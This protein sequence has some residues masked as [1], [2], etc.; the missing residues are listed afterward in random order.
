MKIT[1][2]GAGAWG[3]AF[4]TLLIRNG[5]QVMLWSHEQDV[6]DDITRF[7]TNKKFFPDVVLDP[8]IQATHDLKMALKDAAWIVQ[9]IPVAYLRSVLMDV[10]AMVPDAAIKP[11]IL[12]SKGI[13]QDSLM[14][15]SQ[16]LEEIFSSKIS[17]AIVAGPNFAKELA[18]GA[19]TATTVAA[20]DKT[21]TKKV[22]VL[23]GNSFFKPFPSTDPIGAQVGGAI[24]NVIAIAV[25]ICKGKDF[26][27]NTVAYVLTQG[28]AEIALLCEKLGGHKETGYGFSGFGDLVLTCTSN[29]SK[30][31][32]VGVMLGNGKSLEEI[33]GLVP[34]LP[35]GINTIQSVHELGRK[36]GLHLP[37]C[38]AVYE[39]IFGN[40]EFEV[41]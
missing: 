34:V 20:T 4:A 38:N 29:L 18:Q 13:E 27:D 11:W 2:L 22:C 5:H 3:T 39:F 36:L 33:E 28:L 17:Y 15:S 31:F 26:A 41:F 21:L 24:K 37:V 9:A 23:L 12:L 7:H 16:I 10:K 30:N 1:I 32:R 25:G 14:L 8:N 19:P 6:A 35:E 40:K